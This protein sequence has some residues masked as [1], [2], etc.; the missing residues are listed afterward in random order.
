VVATTAF[1]LADGFTRVMRSAVVV[2]A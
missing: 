1:K 2:V